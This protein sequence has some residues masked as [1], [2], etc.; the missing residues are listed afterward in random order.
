MAFENILTEKKDGAG[1]IT[2][3]RPA[4]LNAMSHDLM[5]EVHAALTEFENDEEVRVL[6]MT[7]AGEKAFCA[8][9]DIHEEAEISREKTITPG[10]H[11]PVARQRR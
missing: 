2:L 7:G 9:A 6:I 1:I 11:E 10:R 8:G 4:K 5:Q 3:N